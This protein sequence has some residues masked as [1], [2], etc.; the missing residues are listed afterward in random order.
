MTLARACPQCGRMGRGR[1]ANCAR[2]ARQG[3][4]L[5]DSARWQKL[6]AIVRARD[7]ACVRCG[8]TA[9]LSVH[10]I[11]GDWRNN[12]MSNLV[13]LCRRCHGRADGGKAAR[14]L[15]TRAASSLASTSPVSSNRAE[16]WPTVG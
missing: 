13:T 16:T 3:A 5:Y 11:D 10:H 7:G 6:R 1:C 12:T 9:N 2:P 14:F 8:T 4:S 15:R